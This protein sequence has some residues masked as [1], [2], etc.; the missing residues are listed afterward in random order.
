LS[1]RKIETVEEYLARGGTITKIPTGSSRIKEESLK[2][3]V[4]GP[5]TILSLED[6][7]LFY[8][9]AKPSKAKKQKPSLKIDLN[10]LPESLRNK[11]LAKLK[12]EEQYGEEE[13]YEDE[14]DGDSD[15]DGSDNG[16][17]D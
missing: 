15:E 2:H 14:E 8:G 1:R 17:E 11:F 9:E 3:Q 7:D 4:N 16:D 13:I 12:N 5:V 6:A 10:A